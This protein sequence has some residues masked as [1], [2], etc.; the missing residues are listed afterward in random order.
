MSVLGGFVVFF[1]DADA[2]VLVRGW[3]QSQGELVG[4]DET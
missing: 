2:P 1:D 4:G 3:G